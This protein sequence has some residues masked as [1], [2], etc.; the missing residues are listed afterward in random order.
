MDADETLRRMRRALLLK[1][2]HVGVMRDDRSATDSA[3]CDAAVMHA[4]EAAEHAEQLDKWLAA[5]G[6]WPSAWTH[7][8]GT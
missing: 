5:G 4:M 8:R 1:N 2:V 3:H 7:T 6:E